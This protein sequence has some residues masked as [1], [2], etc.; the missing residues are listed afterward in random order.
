MRIG[1][2]S[3][4]F[5][6]V[7]AGT[8]QY[9]EAKKAL[10]SVNNQARHKCQLTTFAMKFRGKSQQQTAQIMAKAAN[11]GNFAKIVSLVGSQPCDKDRSRVINEAT[12]HG[13]TPSKGGNAL[14]RELLSRVD[15]T[16]NWYDFDTTFYCS[17]ARA[18][19]CS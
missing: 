8:N 19:R 6:A 3:E 7:L 1:A 12:F 13:S 15:K 11:E 14:P 10:R 17:H 9:S 5:S 2:Q 4:I 16:K 18:L